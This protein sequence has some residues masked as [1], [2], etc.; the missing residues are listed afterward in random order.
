MAQEREQRRTIVNATMKLRISC[1]TDPLHDLLTNDFAKYRRSYIVSGK[2]LSM[3][4]F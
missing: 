1:P 4:S 2:C 3:F